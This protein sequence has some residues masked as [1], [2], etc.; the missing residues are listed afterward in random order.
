MRFERGPYGIVGI[1]MV[2][3]NE[4]VVLHALD[5]LQNHTLPYVL[6]TYSREHNGKTEIIIDCTGMQR[7]SEMHNITWKDPA[8]KW[9][10]VSAFVLSI[11]EAF[12]SFLDPDGFQTDEDCVFFDEKASRLMW[13]YL[14]ISHRQIA[15]TPLF[16][17]L[18]KLLM[19]PFF[20]EILSEED[21]NQIT[22]FLRE[23]KE[24]EL[25]RVLARQS[26]ASAKTTDKLHVSQQAS[27]L[28]LQLIVMAISLFILFTMHWSLFFYIIYELIFILCL[29][30]ILVFPFDKAAREKEVKII[31]S[32]P[33]VLSEKELLF[34]QKA[35]TVDER[36]RVSKPVSPAYL[37]GETNQS[38]KNQPM[39]RVIWVEDF[40]VGSDELLC[41]LTLHDPSI[42][43]R[44]ARI[45]CRKN[46]YFLVDLS[47]ESGT[48]LNDKRLYSY[49]ETPLQN[50]DRLC[51]GRCRFKFQCEAVS[52]MKGI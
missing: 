14:P 3:E 28:I 49:E 43:Y 33:K 42:S 26:F 30:S 21:R 51:F 16:L 2:A 10:C 44:H 15:Q 39:I 1:E 11:I 47:S 40:L 7:L 20:C 27:W 19:H 50:N 13:C 17:R 32:A 41:D 34:P 18:E 9:D 23:K 38:C 48:F 36:I 45:L 37:I 5:L 8:S 25:K 4:S 24:E 52:N 22:H 31:P 46:V 6:P 29:I 12:D 35:N